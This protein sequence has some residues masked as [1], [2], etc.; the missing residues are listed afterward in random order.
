LE[1]SSGYVKNTLY[2]TFEELI[3]VCMHVCMYV[4]IIKVEYVSFKSA[5]LGVFRFL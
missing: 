2:K 4:C 5:L 3:K 1:E